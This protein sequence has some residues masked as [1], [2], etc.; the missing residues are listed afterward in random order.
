M[1]LC[2]NKDVPIETRDRIRLIAYQNLWEKWL[3]LEKSVKKFK[4]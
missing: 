4:G 1:P 3:K 2:F